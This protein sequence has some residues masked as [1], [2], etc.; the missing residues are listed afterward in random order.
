MTGAATV[1]LP[2]GNEYVIVARYAYD[3]TDVTKVVYLGVVTGLIEETVTTTKYLQA[4]LRADGSLVSGRYNERKGSL[5]HI[6]EPEYIEWDSTEE[7]YPIVFDSIGDW[8]VT[9]AVAPPEGF[10]TDHEVLANG[11]QQ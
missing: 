10:V 11:G 1:A 5:L 9:T 6:I 2:A 4:L 7:T 3:D 8:T